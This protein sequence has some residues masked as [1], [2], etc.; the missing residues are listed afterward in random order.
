MTAG[1][2]KATKE[3]HVIDSC[4]LNQTTRYNTF[5]FTSCIFCSDLLRSATVFRGGIFFSAATR[6]LLS[7]TEK[8][9]VT[10]SLQGPVLLSLGCHAVNMMSVHAVSGLIKG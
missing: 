2:N 9:L 4:H 8:Y 7:S 3:I 10:I 5:H 1:N 6:V